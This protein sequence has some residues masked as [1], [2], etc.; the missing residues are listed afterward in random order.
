VLVGRRSQADGNFPRSL[1]RTGH[2]MEGSRRKRAPQFTPFD[3]M[4]WYYAKGSQR[5]GPISEDEFRRLAQNGTITAGTLVWRQGMPQWAPRGM[6]LVPGG[7]DVV[8]E[9]SIACASCG[10]HVPVNE[11]FVLAEKNYCATCKPQILQRLNDGLPLVSSAAEEMRKAYLKHES[12][13]KS[14][15]LLYFLAGFAFLF[16]G[17]GI[18]AATIGEEASG[19]ELA[20]GMV[21]ALAFSA[22]FI[23]LGASLRRLRRWTRIPIGI[24]SG[25]GLLGFPVG[26]L[27]HGYILYLVF[28]EKGKMVFSEEYR[29]VMRQTPHIKYRTSVV[30]WVIL[31]IL[32]FILLGVIAMNVFR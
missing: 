13:V 15:S 27:I 19:G 2:A 30:V 22:G 11:S 9:G 16:G 18:L 31:G 24:I 26:T 23:A 3:R 28:S 21:V 20:G 17:V 25:I 7:F 6:S 4:E 1:F 32:V 29:D 12:S 10:R 14:I 5:C 8:P